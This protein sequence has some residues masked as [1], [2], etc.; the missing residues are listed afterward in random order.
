MTVTCTRPIQG[1]FDRPA[2]TLLAM[3]SP[4]HVRK[5]TARRDLAV[6]SPTPGASGWPSPGQPLQAP[7]VFIHNTAIAKAQRVEAIAW[8]D[9]VEGRT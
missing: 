2:W 6:V 3:R 5:S 4:Q 1:F 8:S 7:M 9:E